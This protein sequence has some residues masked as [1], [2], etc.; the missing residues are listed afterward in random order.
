MSIF[1]INEITARGAGPDIIRSHLL[2]YR[3]LLLPPPQL[4]EVNSLF[5]FQNHQHIVMD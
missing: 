1:F 2:L 3:D 5:Q 4:Q